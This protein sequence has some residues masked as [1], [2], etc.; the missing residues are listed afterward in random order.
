MSEQENFSTE[1][2]QEDVEAHSHKR[3]KLMNDEG[4]KDEDDSSDDFEAHRKRSL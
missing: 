4:R 2:E 1:E 3:G